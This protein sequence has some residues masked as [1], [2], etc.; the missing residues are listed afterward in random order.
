MLCRRRGGLVVYNIAVCACG[1]RRYV[2]DDT[3]SM[4]LYLT[5]MLSTDE[6]S[7]QCLATRGDFRGHKEVTLKLYG[8]HSR[9][10]MSF[11]IP[12][13]FRGN[14]TPPPTK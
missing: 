9:C 5:K 12:R 4:K 7:Y 14:F 2:E 10:L 11:F 3:L 1:H 13:I 6:G 8:N